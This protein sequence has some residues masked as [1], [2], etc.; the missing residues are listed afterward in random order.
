M[1]I[2]VIA[3]A[4]TMGIYNIYGTIVNASALKSIIKY[5]YKCWNIKKRAT[6]KIT[7]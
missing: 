4:F 3:V 1:K 5:D 7:T 6:I 2:S